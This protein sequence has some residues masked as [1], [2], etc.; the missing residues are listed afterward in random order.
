MARKKRQNWCA[1]VIAIFAL[2]TS[3]AA[4][5]LAGLSYRAQFREELNVEVSHDDLGFL[6]VFSLSQTKGSSPGVTRA[7]SWRRVAI[8]NVSNK[9]LSVASIRFAEGD[10]SAFD[11]STPF[12]E[13]IKYE[14][15]NIHLRDAVGLPLYLGAGESRVVYALVPFTVPQA[16]QQQMFRIMLKNPPTS[17]TLVFATINSPAFFQFLFEDGEER[18]RYLR[19]R[20]GADIDS[21]TWDYIAIT[22]RMF[23]HILDG[24]RFIDAANDAPDGAVFDDTVYVFGQLLRW[25]N[26]QTGMDLS[27]FDQQYSTYHIYVQT[28]SGRIQDIRLPTT[29]IP[30]TANA[31]VLRENQIS[32]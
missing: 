4:V 27:S 29:A 16:L 8:N 19:D 21:V 25:I 20:Q 14:G 1:T 28:S 12:F 15:K 24:V 13:E 17:E 11:A 10:Q 26:E 30:L 2:V 22:R 3:I 9:P 7:A 5:V 31:A 32:R 18:L 23:A 6:H